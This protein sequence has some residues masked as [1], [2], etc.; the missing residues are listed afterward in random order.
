MEHTPDHHVNEEQMHPDYLERETRFR[1]QAAKLWDAEGE[2][3]ARIRT[4]VSLSEE[5][6]MDR[7]I[8]AYSDLEK[9][10]EALSGEI[11]RE[12]GKA[13]Q[14]ATETLYGGG[15]GKKFSEHLTSVAN[16]PD[17]RLEALMNTATRSGQGELARAIAVSAYERGERTI[18]INSWAAAHPERAAALERIK[19]TP[20]AEQF[21]TRTK[22]AMR[23]PKAALQD[24]VPTAEDERRAAE[25]EAASNV[26][27]Y[28]EFFGP[29]VRRQVGGRVS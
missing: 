27:K 8:S 29:T 1:D 25:A 15:N 24:L 9:T 11:G 16:V 6:R 14:E 5:E 20:G 22:L 21:Y 2:A 28:A 18:F 13:I 17:E 12:E 3:R 10:L 23:P 19:G 7:Y 4:D 26:T